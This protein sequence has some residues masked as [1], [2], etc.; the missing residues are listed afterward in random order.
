MFLFKKETELK[1][2]RT[3]IRIQFSS[4]I[5]KTV[6]SV[7]NFNQ[8]LM[9]TINKFALHRTRLHVVKT[10]IV[11]TLTINNLRIIIQ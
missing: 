7:F 3:E 8:A 2:K 11:V 10:K 5:S 6:K 4:H 9:V 1:K